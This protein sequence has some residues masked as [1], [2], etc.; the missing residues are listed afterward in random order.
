VS[1]REYRG[2][3]DRSRHNARYDN[4]RV[5]RRNDQRGNRSAHRKPESSNNKGDHNRRSN[6]GEEHGRR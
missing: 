3:D 1:I 2:G 5:E 4:H 6:R